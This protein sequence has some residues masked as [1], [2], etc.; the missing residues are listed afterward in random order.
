MWFL[1]AI[2]VIVL[3]AGP[4]ACVMVFRMRREL[5]DVR[6]ENRAVARQ[7]R[8]L[9]EEFA[10]RPAAL[11]DSRPS[12]SRESTEPQLPGQPEADV[13]RAPAISSPG[14]G[15]RLVWR[16]DFEALFGGQWLTWIGVLAIFFGTAFFL[17]HDLGGHPLAGL[18]Q[19]LTGILVGALFIVVGW[20]L[21]LRT[22][23]F[24]GRGLLGGGMALLDLSAY[25]AHGFHHLVPGTVVY[26]L[27]LGVAFLGAAT[28]LVHNS[29]AVAG[30]TLVGALLTPPLLKPEGDPAVVLFPYLFVV[31]LGVFVV[32][33]RRRWPLL[34]FLGFLGT[35]VLVL[36][37]WAEYYTPDHRRVVLPGVGGLW[38]LFALQLVRSRPQPGLWAIAR[39]VIVVLNGLMFEVFLARVLAPDLVRFRGTT[40]AVLALAYIVGA[41]ALEGWSVG[42]EEPDAVGP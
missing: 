22:Q 7:L 3:L 11:Q 31:N 5:R 28:A 10:S 1:A 33:T 2:A 27:L 30:L 8:L 26:P 6:R 21:A 9:V 37:W 34:S 39:S 15:S 20:G 18:G 32:A 17:A 38:L 42:D 19:V 23:P 12:S 24:L 29:L 40:C 13:A 35:L 14:A 41:R 25:A 4:V 16:R 36:G